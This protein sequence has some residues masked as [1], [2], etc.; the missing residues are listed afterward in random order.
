MLQYL[1]AG[2]VLGSAYALTST[3]VVMTLVSAGVLNF[4]FGA[5]A[6]Q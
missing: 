5:M 1:I 6:F 4:S 2:L 3:G